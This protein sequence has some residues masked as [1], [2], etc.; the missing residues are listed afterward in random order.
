M[1]GVQTC[2]LPICIGIATVKGLSMGLDCPFVLVPTLDI[3]SQKGQ[4]FD[5]IV[6]PVID[7]RKKRLYTAFYEK[8]KRISDYMD[9]SPKTLLDKIAQFNKV[10]ITGPDALLLA[11]DRTGWQ[12]D[13]FFD[14]GYSRAL[15]HY[16]LDFYT[17]YGPSDFTDKP[18]Y[19][20]PSEAEETLMKREKGT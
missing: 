2:A 11:I 1:T 20:R 3:Y 4:H 14:A 9:L 17:R 18:I 15:I 7:A 19:L 10:W 12:I 8:N 5:G 16:G 13:P 6:V